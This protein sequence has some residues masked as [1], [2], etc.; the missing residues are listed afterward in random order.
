MSVPKGKRGI[1]DMEFFRLSNELYA[2]L[3]DWLLRDFGV[4]DKVRKSKNKEEPDELLKF[5]AWY[6]EHI[7]KHI[8]AILDRY[9]EYLITANTI[10]PATYAEL[11]TR[12]NYQNYA[13]GQLEYLEQYLQHALL[14]L[15]IAKAKTLRYFD[16]I[17]HTISIVKLWRK[18]NS[19]IKK[20]LDAKFKNKED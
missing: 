18:S 5:P 15:P 16:L 7:R 13:L 3:I 4:R 9:M 20:I 6:I 1:S 12:R 8:L 14:K 17:E 2:V 19:R 11:E 10:Y